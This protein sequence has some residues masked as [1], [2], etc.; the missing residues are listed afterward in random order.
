MPM[1]RK[2]TL[3]SGSRAA[4]RPGRFE[5]RCRVVKSCMSMDAQLQRTRKTEEYENEK[6]HAAK[7]VLLGGPARFRDSLFL[8]NACKRAV[9]VPP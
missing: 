6:W 3:S 4:F 7:L 8:R 2:V 9:G 1:A 5:H